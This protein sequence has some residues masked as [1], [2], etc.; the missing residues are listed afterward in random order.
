MDQK[1][2]TVENSLNEADI[3]LEK[4]LKTEKTEKTEIF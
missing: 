1:I 3:F 2:Y 4:P